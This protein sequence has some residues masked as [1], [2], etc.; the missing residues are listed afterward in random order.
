MAEVGQYQTALLGKTGMP[1]PI[2]SLLVAF[3]PLSLFETVSVARATRISQNE[4]DA[5]RP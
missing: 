1:P 5:N 4:A 3:L 2:S